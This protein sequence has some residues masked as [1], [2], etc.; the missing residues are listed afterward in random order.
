MAQFMEWLFLKYKMETVTENI[1]KI[2]ERLREIF[3]S[4]IGVISC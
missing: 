1:K 4:S 2:K 3:S